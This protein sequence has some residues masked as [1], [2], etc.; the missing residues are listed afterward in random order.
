MAG[1]AK[2]LH[3]AIALQRLE[4]RL[5]DGMIP[6][7]RAYAGSTARRIANLCTR[8]AGKS[9]TALRRLLRRALRTRGGR[10]L[11]INETR[12]ECERIA[13]SG[14]NGDGLVPLLEAMGVAHKL[15]QTKLRITF[16]DID[17][18]INLVGA[19][20]ETAI[21]KLRG[22]AYHGVIIDEAQKMPHLENLIDQ[23]LGAAMMDFGGS[24]E[25][26][27]TPSEDCAGLFYEAT[28]GGSAGAWEVHRW[29]ILD[30]PYFGASSDERYARTIAVYLADTGRTLD[31]PVVQRE[32]FGRWVKSDSR[33]VYPVFSVP[34]EQLVYAPAR[35]YIDG[36]PDWDAALRDMPLRPDGRSY[37]WLHSV[38]IDIGYNPDPFAFVVWSWTRDLPGLWELGS[39]SQQNLIP[40]AQA[41]ILADLNQRLNPVEM[42]AD[43]G[44][45]AKGVVAGWSEG[46]LERLAIPVAEAEKSQKS[47]NIEWMGNDIRKGL[48][49]V[50][51]GGAWLTEA[52]K[53]T[54]L[55]S[56]TGKYVENPKTANHC[57]DGGLY[58][59]RSAS[60]YRSEA[61]PEAPKLGTAAWSAV[62][63]E[64]MESARFDDAGGFDDGW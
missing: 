50:R 45:V 54:W 36:T 9:R 21:R 39:W 30:N 31:D 53:H 43:A 26:L 37:E 25:L 13:W 56:R 58:G 35:A 61:P 57:L 10:F 52:E 12:A 44:G 7:Q 49:R 28:E 33:H 22:G 62:Q 46:W 63:E 41:V 48:V 64:R 4:S 38:G 14:V 27:G 15:D 6:Q 59:F 8:R 20:D 32:Y 34:R 51:E 55:V 11:Y 60:H 23:V 2:K 5:F 47:T 24:I 42:V 3:R 16:A 40:D 29:S 17:C 18:Q 19:D 1:L